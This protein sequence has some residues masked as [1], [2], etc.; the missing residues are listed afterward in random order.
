MAKRL[1]QTMKLKIVNVVAGIGYD[2]IL[3]MANPKMR[4][5]LWSFDSI[6][7]YLRRCIRVQAPLCFPDKLSVA[8]ANFL[9]EAIED[10]I[11][12]VLYS[13]RRHE[14]SH[15]WEKKVVESEPL[16]SYP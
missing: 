8:E 9:H 14:I 2:Y 1:T 15:L 6:P 5:D 16:I 3:M 12:E 10:F 13:V 7:D 11:K 4:G